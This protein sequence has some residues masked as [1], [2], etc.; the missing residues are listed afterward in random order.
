MGVFPKFQKNL[1]NNFKS[2]TT[3]PTRE[4]NYSAFERSGIGL[5]FWSREP[6][7]PRT[8]LFRI[9]AG[10]CSNNRIL[11]GFVAQG[12]LEEGHGVPFLYRSKTFEKT[13]FRQKLN[14]GL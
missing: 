9:R 13:V 2:L 12:L 8:P 6:L 11:L 7:S 14:F 1:F 3:T 4:M 10:V 5:S